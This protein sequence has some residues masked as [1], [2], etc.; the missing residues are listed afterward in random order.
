[1]SIAGRR[2][3]RDAAPQ[4]ASELGCAPADDLREV[5][6]RVGELGEGGGQRREPAPR[7][8]VRHLR[9]E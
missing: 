7:V 2:F 9:G 5:A 8:G 4:A 3:V 1:M 6:Q